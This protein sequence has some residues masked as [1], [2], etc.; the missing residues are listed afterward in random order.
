MTDK[1]RSRI[2]G[3]APEPFGAEPEMTP[4]TTLAPADAGARPRPGSPG[5]R[6]GASR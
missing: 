2:V 3:M 5:A 4:C 6:R 1:D